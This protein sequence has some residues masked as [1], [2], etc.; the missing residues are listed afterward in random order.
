MK[1]ESENSVCII[2]GNERVVAP[3]AAGSHDA[4]QSELHL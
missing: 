2:T 4:S 1:K 3:S